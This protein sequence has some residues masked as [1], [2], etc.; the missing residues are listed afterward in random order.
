MLLQSS[1]GQGVVETFGIAHQPPCP[2]KVAGDQ[3]DFVDCAQPLA[4]QGEVVGFGSA[5][6]HP[7][8]IG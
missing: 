6:I 5:R 7:V 8:G 2:R 4:R 3:E 1:S